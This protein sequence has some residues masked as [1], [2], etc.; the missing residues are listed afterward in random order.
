MNQMYLTLPSN[1]S[2]N[3]FPNNTL[4]NFKIKLP[5]EIDLE[6]EIWEVG[7]SE[8]Q[9]P[10]TWRNLKRYAHGDFVFIDKEEKHFYTRH[11]PAGYYGKAEEIVSV[12]NEASGEFAEMS[13]NRT[14]RRIKI[15]LKPGFKMRISSYMSKML[16]LPRTVKNVNIEDN[17]DEIYSDV[18]ADLD[19][20]IEY[21]YVYCD[22]VLHQMVG[23]VSVPLLRI[24]PVPEEP[25]T[26]IVKTYEHIQYVPMRGGSIQS[27]EIDIRDNFGDPVPFESGKVVVILHMR[28][29]GYTPITT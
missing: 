20:R 1:S 9:F 16:K 12:M 14:T 17:Y 8:I 7:L 3:Y 28:K 11:V 24:V 23:D 19:F 22:L 2:M 27:V 15:K 13:Y 4:T 29:A 25:M 10:H 5:K 26:N 21:L 6:T 18:V